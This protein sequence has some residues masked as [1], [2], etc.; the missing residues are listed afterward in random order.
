MKHD[1]Y[2][3]KYTVQFIESGPGAGAA[4]TLRR[5]EASH[6]AKAVWQGD[7]VERYDARVA[8]AKAEAS[9]ALAARFEQTLKETM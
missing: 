7:A 4:E 9:A 5:Y 2:D 8:L 3:G 6:R 1:F